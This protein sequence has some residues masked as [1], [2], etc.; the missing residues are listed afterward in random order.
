[1][2]TDS[3]RSG[4]DSVDEIMAGWQQV[5]PDL[6]VT[7]LAVIL[8][9]Q[10]VRDHIDRSLHELFAR[11]HLSAADFALLVTLR[12]LGPAPNAATLAADLKITAG[13]L[14]VRLERLRA[15]GLVTR[16]PDPRDSRAQLVTLTQLGHDTFD[17]AAPA[18]LENEARLLRALTPDQRAQL[19]ELL[20]ALLA[21]YEA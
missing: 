7:P 19:A 17:A 18:H 4:T 1:M 16:T 13:T 9:L 10:R 12:R 15:A 2:A 3:P 8:R 14:S 11:Y 21:D 6:D 20:R 5:R